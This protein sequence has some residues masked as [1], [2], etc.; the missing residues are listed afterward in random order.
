MPCLVHAYIEIETTGSHTQF[1]DKF[2]TRFYIAQLFRLIGQNPGHL[3]AL[4]DLA[5]TDLERFVRFVNLMMND[6][7]YLLDDL[8][9]TLAKIS[10]CQKQMDNKA[11]WD[12][13]SPEDRQETEKKLSQYENVIKSDIQL[14]TVSLRFIHFFTSR[15][16][17]PFLAPEIVD[18]L[19]AMLDYNIFML[20][21]PRCQDLKVRDPE[22]LGFK[23]KTLLADVINIFLALGRE[24]E[25]Q[26][27]VAKDGRSYSKDLF[28]RAGKIAL[29]TSIKTESEL[30][31]MR[32]LVKRVEEIRATE[33]E[34]DA[35]GDIPEEFLGTSARFVAA[36]RTH[37][38][39]ADPLTYDLMRDPVILPTSK[40]VIDRST[41]KQHHLSDQTDPFNR[42]PLKWEDI[43]DAPEIKQQI[44]AFIADRRSKR[45]GAVAAVEEALGSG[46]EGGRQV[47]AE[48]VPG[49]PA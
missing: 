39:G 2:N 16:K 28:D 44:D 8:L 47:S 42:M 41:I 12:A 21:G 7:T 9:N 32:E 46:P 17:R 5:K 36:C 26:H 22:K 11:E 33:Q 20:A 19:A 27:A 23:P 31:P 25:F 24:D 14:G 30:E 34:D 15:A 37:C 48:D 38:G 10:E 4:K 18:R 45:K 40:T 13:M 29:R 1:Y 49:G 43:Q 35:M 3:D 6:T